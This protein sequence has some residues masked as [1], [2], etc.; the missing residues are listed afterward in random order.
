MNNIQKAF[1]AKAQMSGLRM[2][3]GGYFDPS[4]MQPPS[5]LSS[6]LQGLASTATES[7]RT[8][9]GLQG[10]IA[11]RNVASAPTPM[12]Q[13]QMPQM[14]QAFA[15]GGNVQNIQNIGLRQQGTVRGPGTGTSDSVPAMLS[16]G[17]Y[18]LPADTVRHIGKEN[19]DQLKDATHAPVNNGLRGGYADGGMPDR[20]TM[21]A[22]DAAKQLGQSLRGTFPDLRTQGKINEDNAYSAVQGGTATPAQQSLR[23]NSQK[24]LNSPGAQTMPWDVI[25]PVTGLGLLGARGAGAVADAG[26]GVVSKI[27]GAASDIASGVGNAASSAWNGVRG[28]FSKAP[29]AGESVAAGA[30]PTASAAGPTLSASRELAPYAAPAEA[31]T[32][33]LGVRQ[34]TGLA[35][36]AVGPQSVAASGSLMSQTHASAPD[37]VPTAPAAASAATPMTPQQKWLVENGV[38]MDSQNSLPTSLR[39][40]GGPNPGT[41]INLDFSKRSPIRTVEGGQAV[42]LGIFGGNANI[43]GSSSKL[44]GGKIDTFTGIGTPDGGKGDQLQREMTAQKIADMNRTSD[45]QREVHGLRMADNDAGTM[46]FGSGG[47][48]RY[49]GVAAVNARNAAEANAVNERNSLRSND[50]ARWQGERQ[51]QQNLRQMQWDRNKFGVEQGNKDREFNQKQDETDFGQRDKATKDL[52]DQ[53][54][55]MFAG[56]DGKPDTA[57]VGAASQAIHDELG[58]R[59][60]DLAKVP[61]GSQH[62][63]EAQATMKTLGR[64]GIAA[65]GPDDLRQLMSQAAIKDRVMQTH[66]ILPG[67]SVPVDSRLSGYA[68]DPK[69]APG[70]N[71]FGSD[72][73]TLGNG[74]KVR[75]N[76]LRY[77]EPANAFWPDFRHVNSTQFSAGL[78]GEK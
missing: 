75:A 51:L 10:Q 3:D 50:T 20:R 39:G 69:T 14:P 22:W 15:N 62:Y 72:T 33:P 59:I 78:K 52:N 17:E 45:L 12:Q 40:N 16:K 42:N 4:L 70:S 36:R 71:I 32:T 48:S 56:P 19:L 53:L 35:A 37:S 30:T 21:P 27:G 29:A 64:K 11:A 68:I 63:A 58:A 6:A 74:S 18:V 46:G 43:Y 65:L 55:T 73:V 34:A 31:A 67:G 54:G 41:G 77:T 44:D 28:M 5:S 47:G 38:N 76:N 13:P 26:P 23:D 8:N 24:I 49:T 25:A 2:A 57:R 7:I 66:S 61:A 60:Q 1:K 9:T